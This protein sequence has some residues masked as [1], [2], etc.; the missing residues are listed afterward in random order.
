VNGVT[1]TFNDQDGNKRVDYI[2]SP[3]FDGET[4]AVYKSAANVWSGKII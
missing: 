4:A 2:S 1:S 3:Y